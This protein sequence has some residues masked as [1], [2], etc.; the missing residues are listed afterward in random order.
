MKSARTGVGHAVV[1]V[2]SHEAVPVCSKR[3]GPHV[4]GKPVGVEQGTHYTREPG[5][6]SVPTT[7]PE[8]WG[9][10]IR[11]C[12]RHD[13]RSLLDA[14]EPLL[15]PPGRPVP[16]PGEALQR[17]HDAAH[18]KFLEV[19]DGDPDSDLLKRA[20]YQLSYRIGPAGGEQTG[21]G[22]PRR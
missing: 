17:W 14:I 19:V 8:H 12:V 5:P 1:W 11:R 2:P 22:G 21:M 7:T 20:H 4:G 15:Q 16:E 18:Q 13:R 3:A 9:P 10:I 6:A